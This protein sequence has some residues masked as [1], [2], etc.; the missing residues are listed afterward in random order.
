MNRIMVKAKTIKKFKILQ[1]SKAY[2]VQEL[3]NNT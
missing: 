1:V 2:I 3:I